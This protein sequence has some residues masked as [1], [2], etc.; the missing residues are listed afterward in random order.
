MNGWKKTISITLGAVLASVIALSQMSCMSPEDQQAM[1]QLNTALQ[2][3]V[4]TVQKDKDTVIE[5]QA[6]LAKYKDSFGQVMAD[7]KSGKMPAESGMVLLGQIMANFNAT[8]A[9]IA[10]VQK[11]IDEN[12]AVAKNVQASIANMK[13]RDIPWFAYDLPLC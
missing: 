10:Q 7:I 3:A 8:Q 1:G 4:V 11:A 13:G 9:K 6:E 12:M 5:L 2:N